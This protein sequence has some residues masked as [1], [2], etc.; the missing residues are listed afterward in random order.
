MSNVVKLRCNEQDDAQRRLAASLEAA[1]M[2]L[3]SLLYR[4]EAVFQQCLDAEEKLKAMESTPEQLVLL[5]HV[6]KFQEQLFNA[7]LQLR[8]DTASLTRATAPLIEA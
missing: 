5:A 3:N 8:R 6:R 7:M 1:T 4:T 2:S